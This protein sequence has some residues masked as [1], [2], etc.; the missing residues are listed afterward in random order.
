[1]VQDIPINTNR[2]EKS[3]GDGTLYIN[4]TEENPWDPVSKVFKMFTHTIKYPP[5]EV[6]KS[7]NYNICVYVKTSIR[8]TFKYEKPTYKVEKVEIY[9]RINDDISIMDPLILGFIYGRSK[10]YYTY[11]HL[12]RHTP[13]YGYL[14]GEGLISQNDLLTRLLEE[15]GSSIG[16]AKKYVI[17][18]NQKPKDIVVPITYPESGHNKDNKITVKKYPD[19][20][21]LD[22]YEHTIN[23]DVD[24]FYISCN[25]NSMYF[26]TGVGSGYYRLG[27]V[28]VYREKTGSKKPVLFQLNFPGRKTYEYTYFDFVAELKTGK[29]DAKK[30]TELSTIIPPDNQLKVRLEA[31]REKLKEAITFVNQDGLKN[32]NI[33]SKEENVGQGPF[34]KVILKPNTNDAKEG[35]SVGP[36]KVYKNQLFTLEPGK[37]IEGDFLDDIARSKFSSITVFYNSKNQALL[38]EFDQGGGSKNYFKRANKDGD[39]WDG[40]IILNTSDGE[41]TK[42]LTE[43]EK[44][45]KVIT[46]DSSST[47][48]RDAGIGT[49]VTA[50]LGAGGGAGY[51]IYKYPQVFLSLIGR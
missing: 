10:V 43:I 35:S 51:A 8:Y 1:M 30:I 50:I 14:S 45:E 2:T 16:R 34:K 47:V 25:R 11:N 36:W 48:G 20:A 5:S 15:I 29:S 26:Q 41:L 7:S 24:G 13:K 42:K 4:V 23:A 44:F 33:S 22:K 32:E 18:L 46:G 17:N 49:G 40:E 3:Y 31:E 39:S 19:E 38:V 12:T 21:G 28:T 6:Y 37:K 27:T 9:F